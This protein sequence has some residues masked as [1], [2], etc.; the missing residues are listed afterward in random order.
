MLFDESYNDVQGN[1]S[2]DWTVKNGEG[3]THEYMELYRSEGDSSGK[4]LKRQFSEDATG[5][6]TIDLEFANSST[7]GG[8]GRAQ[9]N[10]AAKSAQGSSNTVLSMQ[11]QGNEVKV[12]T[13][14]SY[15]TL[16]TVVLEEKAMAKV[17]V[18]TVEDKIYVGIN[19]GELKEYPL[20]NGMDMRQVDSAYWTLADKTKYGVGIRLYA[21]KASAAV[22]NTDEF[23]IQADLD[24]I[25][26]ANMWGIVQNFSVPIKG[27]RNT[28]FSWTSDHASATVDNTTGVVDI[29]RG[30]YN[31]QAKLTVTGTQNGKSA[32]KEFNLTILGEEVTQERE[33]DLIYVN[34]E[35]LNLAK[36]EIEANNHTFVEAYKTLVLEA[37]AELAKAIDPVT[38]KTLIPA[39]G[40]IHDYYTIAS[41]FWP[42]PTKEDGLPWIYKDGEF[43]PTTAG[44]DTDWKRLRE[45]F[46]SLD[47]LTLAYYFTEDQT[48]INK[49]K[50]IVQVWFINEETKVNP[51]INYGKARPGTEDG[52]NFAVIDWTDIGK[53]ITA[54]QML[55]KN[56]LWSDSDRTVMGKWLNE[57]YTWLTTSEFGIA[58]DN[59]TNNHGSNYDYQVVGLMIYL[60]KINEAEAKIREAMTKR[61]EAQID[62]DGSQPLELKRTKSVSYTVNNLWALVRLADLSRRFTEVDLWT[63]ETEK[64]VNLKKGYDFV[65]P[66][67]LGEKEWTWKQITGGGVEASLKDWALP[68]FSRSELM[69]GEKILPN[70]LNGYHEFSYNDI[71]VYAPLDIDENGAPTEKGLVYLNEER[72]NLAKREIEANNHTFVEAYKTLVLEADAELAKAIDPVTNKT[73]I[74]ASGDIHDYYSIAPYWW[75][76]P[77]TENGMPWIHKDGVLNPITRGSD[78]DFTRLREMFTSLNTLTLAYYFTEDQKYINKAKEI[79]QVWFINEET[80]VN[81]HVSFGQAIPGKVSGTMFG[82]IEWTDIGKVITT[83]QVLEKNQLL[84]ESELASMKDWFNQYLI[85]LRTSEFGIGAS[86]RTNNHATNYDY[87]VAGLMIYLGKVNEAEALIE[88]T[89]I[90]RIEAHIAPDGSQPEELRRTK[91]VSYTVNNLWALV[92]LADLSR[93]F[94]NVD[95]WSYKSDEGVS[96]KS[97]YDFVIPYILGEK[98]WTWE[99]I[100]GGGVEAS[101]K[102]WALPMFS[103]SELMLGEKILPNELNGYH[104]FSYNDILVYAPLDYVAPIYEI[105]TITDQSA[106][107]LTQGYESGSQ[108]TVTID[109]YNNG[110]RNLSNLKATITG[111]NFIITQ[112]EGTLDSGAKTSFTVKAKDGLAAGTYTETITISAD[113]LTDVTFNV[114]QVVS[115]AAVKPVDSSGGDNTGEPSAPTTS[116]TTGDK[117]EILINGKIEHLGIAKTAQANGQTVTTIV[118]DEEKMKQRLEATPK[119]AVI[120]IPVVTGSEV[121]IGE[122][123][124]RMIKNMEAKKAIIELRTELA[125]YT[126]PAQ[127]IHINDVLERFGV[128]LALEDIRIKI[129]I[130]TP[131]DDMVEVVENMATNRGFSMI[132]PPVNFEVK[133]VYKDRTE[134][135]SKFNSYVKR[136]IVIPEGIDP[137]RITTGLIVEMDGTVR[138][139][140]TKVVNKDDRFHVQI[141]SLTNSTYVVVENRQEFRDLENHWAKDTVNQMASRMIIQGTGHE[142]FSPDQEI[143]RAEFAAILVKGL[144]VDLADR[145]GSFMDVKATDWNSSAINTAYSYNIINGFED[146][147]FRPNDKVTREQAMVILSRAMV[148]TDLKSKSPTRATSAILSSFQDVSDAS[149]WAMTGIAASVQAELITGRSSMKLV[150]KGFITR[151]EV[152][153]MI[154]RLLE[155]SDLI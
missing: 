1:L 31:Q 76:N 122:L 151:A 6:V 148:I 130:A 57:Y 102:D 42:D 27:T 30:D 97:G 143:T 71:L 128:N 5:I 145:T 14:S 133:A 92:R 118:M 93:R 54:I 60:G 106:T 69:L 89:M 24:E 119:G 110:T 114:T 137:D 21:M 136:S 53:V 66:Y 84:A 113:N 144:G 105:A 126:L 94:T 55:E 12:K 36:R 63:Y 96:L 39:S 101:L 40:D 129:V 23:N 45:M 43:N 75:P 20:V 17:V 134:E 100:T 33:T 142:M 90:K 131:T 72:L 44:P 62:P 9:F 77:D 3:Y 26:I 83:L 4:A 22:P 87:Q 50:E 25:S 103:R 147:T 146:G 74:P 150:P 132:L 19:S 58:E 2:M 35:R 52:T 98:E 32:Q 47:T 91:S 82:I 135:V 67:I 13:G 56:N 123:N 112:P 120:T 115:K 154:E 109:V 153:K 88:E 51:N 65:I 86:T 107:A 108:E 8:A 111:T 124:G 15:E 7:D 73:L 70:E 104:E 11:H 141:K 149:T 116:E 29:T 28:V 81:P 64:G 127:Q 68:M 152:A 10:L 34:E 16:S 18:D 117:A 99:Q 155:K 139:V 48:Y 38:N 61:V 78:T 138:H 37:D 121:V 46:K 85:W 80:K 59:T 95:L 140:P 41:Y 79:V 49:A 125:T